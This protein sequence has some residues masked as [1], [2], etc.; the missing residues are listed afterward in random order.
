MS[1]IIATPLESA[2]WER[3]AA[4][5]LVNAAT[6]AVGCLLAIF[7][8]VVIAGTVSRSGNLPSI[9]GCAVYLASLI[10]VYAMST[11]SHSATSPKWKLL[12]RR[13]DQGTIFLLIA[14]TYTP[15]SIAYLPGAAWWILLAAI[16]VMAIAGFVSK[17]FFA[18][19]V[20]LVS[21]TPYVL[22]GWMPAIGAPT[23]V[24]TIP[25]SIFMWMLVGGVCYTLGTLFLIYDDRIRHFHAIWHLFV[26]AGSVCHF[27]GVLLVV[28]AGHR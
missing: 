20:D 21:V 10:T 6:H 5:E 2:P 1:S 23:I 15:F 13:L 9:V 17:V 12:F 11:L 3:S 8:A 14:A 22:L 19:R 4:D 18:H 26:I 25:L 28:T 16:W 7:G 27:C 24:Q